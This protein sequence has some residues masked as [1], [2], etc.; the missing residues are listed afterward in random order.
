MPHLVVE[1]HYRLVSGINQPSFLQFTY[2]IVCMTVSYVYY[3][4]T[5]SVSGVCVVLINVCF[6]AD[7][8]ASY[9]HFSCL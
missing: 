6:A 9:H 5:E 1:T 4:C 2:D 3:D 7:G 8:I